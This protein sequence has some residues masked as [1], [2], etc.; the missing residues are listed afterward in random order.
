MYADTTIASKA[1]TAIMITCFFSQHFI[2]NCLILFSKSCNFDCIFEIN[3]AGIDS[4]YEI[5]NINDGI[6]NFI[7]RWGIN[8][9][10]EKTISY[11][12]TTAKKMLQ[13]SEST[14]VF[15][16]FHTVIFFLVYIDL[17]LVFYCIYLLFI[18]WPQFKLK[19]HILK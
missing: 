12:V 9:L 3:F 14:F 8:Y 19:N 18:N 17:R 7:L 2:L 1:R 11:L 13:S 6:D 16:F 5:G 4:I 10:G 15:N